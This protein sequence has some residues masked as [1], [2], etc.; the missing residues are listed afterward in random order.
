MPR[1]KPKDPSA[2]ASIS[3]P[4]SLLKLAKGRARSQHI[5]LSQYIAALIRAD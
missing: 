1:P 3:M 4:E 5:S 2:K